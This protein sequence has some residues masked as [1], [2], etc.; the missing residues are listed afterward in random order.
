MK[1]KL[2]SGWARALAVAAPL[3][4]AGAA[5]AQDYVPVDE[6]A[7]TRMDPNPFILGAYG[8]IWVAVVVYVVAI[9]RGLGRA[10]GEIEELRKKVDARRA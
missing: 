9:A 7:R 4:A 8:F 5:W 6:A 3:L 2:T 1:R 10:R